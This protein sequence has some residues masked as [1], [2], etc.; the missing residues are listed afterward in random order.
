MASIPNKP[1]IDFLS[2]LYKYVI[3]TYNSTGNQMSISGKHE[4]NAYKKL[5]DEDGFTY[6]S[7]N[8]KRGDGYVGLTEKGIEF[9][10]DKIWAGELIITRK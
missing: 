7:F 5:S 10:T 9:F 6:V 2:P 3:D 4:Y 8:S 1:V